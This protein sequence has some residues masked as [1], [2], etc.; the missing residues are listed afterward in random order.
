MKKAIIFVLAVSMS[1]FNSCK[2]QD[3][4]N[5]KIIE[6][7]EEFNNK[8]LISSVKILENPFLIDSNGVM[9]LDLGD[10][11]DTHSLR[12]KL[13]KTTKTQKEEDLTI[14]NYELLCHEKKV[15]I[16]EVY[17]KPNNKNVIGRIEIN[18]PYYKTNKGISVGD[19]YKSLKQ[20]YPFGI[21][22]GSQLEGITT[23]Y[24]K[25]IFFLLD[26]KFYTYDIEETKIS[27]QTKIKQI[28]IL[29]RR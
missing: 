19:S 15:I 12:L 18:S 26:A 10:N 21:A 8:L 20:T 22:H 23:F 6:A 29:K 13:K 14:D 16:G 28:I 2:K 17:T 11:V 3:D 27:P 4:E 7:P 1:I 9:G 5:G 24:A 25:G